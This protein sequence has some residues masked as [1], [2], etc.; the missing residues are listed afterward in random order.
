MTLK[1]FVYGTLKPQ[2]ANY[3]TYCEGK[4]IES[5]EVYTF[6]S[7][8][9]LPSLGYPAMT[10]GDNTV[11]GYLL[12]FNNLEVIHNLDELETYSPHRLPEAN[13]YQRQL[14][15]VYTSTHESLEKVWAY[16]MTEAK[17][18]QLKGVPVPSGWWTGK[19]QQLSRG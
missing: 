5:I 16:F 18:V 2:E 15:T 14:T 8:F 1:I 4:V 6:G 12:T 19:H 3:Q 7:L 10:W 17:I 13:E 11:R 9:H